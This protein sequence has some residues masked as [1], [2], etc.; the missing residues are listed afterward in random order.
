MAIGA[1]PARSQTEVDLELVL[2]V[3]ASGSVDAREY[4]L[5]VAGIA[6]AFRDDEVIAAIQSGPLGRIA[7]TLAVWAEANRPKD[8]LAWQIIDGRGAAMV[9]ADRVARYPRSIPAGG[10]GIGKAIWFAIGLLDGNGLDAPR[11]VIDVSGDGRETTFREFSVPVS[12]ARA[13]AQARGIT[14]NG[15]PIL[16]EEPELE[17]YYR[18]EVIV[19]FGAFTEPAGSYEDF[20]RAIRKKLQKEIEYRPEI[21][22][23]DER[24]PIESGG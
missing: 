13:I 23:L 22:R 4:A 8:A 15:L 1:A 7:V 19:G 9:F 21:G 6:A 3:D 20:A 18:N 11:R 5:Q 16:N 10:T 12:Q 2:A 24:L 17:D 14:I